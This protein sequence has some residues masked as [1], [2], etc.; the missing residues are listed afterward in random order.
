MSVTRSDIRKF[1]RDYAKENMK[2]LEEFY[3][4]DEIDFAIELANDMV[5]KTPPLGTGVTH[6]NI[7]KYTMLQGVGA[8]LVQI[9][10]NNIADN[11]TSGVVEHGVQLG[12]GDEYATLKDVQRTLMNN[13]RG[14][15]RDYK[16]AVDF[17]NALGAIGSPY[18]RNSGC[19]GGLG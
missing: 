1:F 15:M 10:L 3:K 6:N 12:I 17:S 16:K 19:G 5:D 9:K 18:G 2:H 4:D 8:I 14:D 13:F 11:S 7:P